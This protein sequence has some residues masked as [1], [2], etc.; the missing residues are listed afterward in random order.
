MDLLGISICGSIWV[1]VTSIFVGTKISPF[2]TPMP[3]HICGQTESNG[4]TP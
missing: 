1:V 3:C 2:D 4:A